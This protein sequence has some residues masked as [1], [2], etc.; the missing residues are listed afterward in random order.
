MLK[1]KK[2][3]F[4]FLGCYSATII[5]IY[6]FQYM[7]YKPRAL[8]VLCPLIAVVLFSLIVWKKRETK[9]SLLVRSGIIAI[10]FICGVINNNP[11]MILYATLLCAADITSF[12]MILRTHIISLIAMGLITPV[13]SITGILP[14]YEFYRDVGVRAHSFGFGYYNVVPYAFLFI[15]LDYFLIKQKKQ[16]KANWGVITFILFLNYAIYKYSTLRLTYYLIYLAIFLYIIL[17]KFHWIK[18]S[19]KIYRPLSWIIYPALFGITIWLHKSFSYNNSMLATLNRLLS[20]RLRLGQIA[21]SKYPVRLFGNHI[22]TNTGET[23]EYFYV[24]SGFLYS[25]LGYG[26]VFTI[27]SLAIYMLLFRHSMMKND[28][29][30]FIWLITVALFSTTNNVWIT[31]ETNPIILYYPIVFQTFRTRYS[32]QIENIKQSILIRR[33]M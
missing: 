11:K 29:E 23:G 28:K 4:V 2:N 7:I 30:L 25:L 17:V 32:K 31:I 27:V 10:F 13:L 14:H 33:F 16:K 6:A 9:K 19:R 5:S 8:W 3:E 20:D 26:L 18:L 12:D 24:D 21:L 1:I 15:I 22:I